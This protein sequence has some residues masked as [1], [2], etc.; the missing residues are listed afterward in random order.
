MK[1]K[2]QRAGA[3][4]PRTITE[5]REL[6]GRARVRPMMVELYR[7]AKARLRGEGAESPAPVTGPADT[8]RLLHELQVH[9]VELELQNAE[10]REARDRME[11]L[12]EKYTDLYDFAPVG[13]F[14]L[15]ADGTIGQ[16]NLTGAHLVGRERGRLVGQG[17]GPL[18]AA[19]QRPCLQAFLKLVFAGA[20]KQSCDFELAGRPLRM[21]NLEAQRSPNGEECRAVVVDITER[22]QAEERVRISEVRYRRLFEAAHDGVLLLDPVTRKIT[23]ANPFMTALLG[24]SHGQLVGKELFEIGLLK[25]EAASRQMFQKLRKS[26]EVRYEDLPLESQDGRHQEVEVVANLYQENGH[27][28]IQCNIRDITERKQVEESLRASE[29]RYRL[30]FELGPV[31]VYSCNREGEIQQFNRRA[32]ELWGR[33]PAPGKAGGR[34]CGSFKM[35][36]PG[37]GILPHAQ[38]PMAEVL[39]GQL[40]EVRDA[41]VIIERPDGS[42]STV[43]VNIRPL[44][45]A[46]GNVTGAINCFYDITERKRAEEAHRHMAVLAASNRGLNAEILRRQAVEESLQQSEQ[47]QGR[48]LEESR[49]MQEQMRQLS[50]QVLQVQEEERKR[51]SRELHDVIAQTLTSIS[52]RLTVLKKEAAL[53]RGGLERNITRTQRLVEKSVNTVHQFARDLRPAVLDDL[54]LIP[55]LH[56]HLKG[57]VARTGICAELIAFAG[58]EKLD[59]ARRTVLFRVA[60]EALTNVARH[61]HASQV[62]VKIQKLKGAIRLRIIDDGKGFGAA[63]VMEARKVNRLGLLGMRERME[64]I[65]GTFN[66][67]SAPGKGTTVCVQLPFVSPPGHPGQGPDKLVHKRQELKTK[68]HEK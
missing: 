4:R 37:G 16:V 19:E 64:M 45:N 67:Q 54:G 51:I 46:Q 31:A 32:A 13:Y 21:V 38:C 28:V 40:P 60:Q 44:L 1:K 66:V 5:L 57:F 50:R 8:Q 48:L 27:A 56:A 23:D 33:R 58:V 29:E 20:T 17:F 62:W 26:H 11:V 41:E 42:R 36:R 34:Y 39:A 6:A 55:A 12:L 10:L 65:K 63:R 25:D 30:L 14:T 35:H 68:N 61:S 2:T 59:P 53:K 49:R 24:Y 52:V 7:Q 47:H 43:L 9:Q 15:A 18:L 22:K 3:K